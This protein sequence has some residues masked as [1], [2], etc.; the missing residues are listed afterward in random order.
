MADLTWV[1]A[2]S[3]DSANVANWHDLATG[4]PPSA[5]G[6]TDYYYLKED[7][8]GVCSLN[9]QVLGHLIIKQE[10]NRHVEFN[11]ATPTFI[12][13]SFYHGLVMHFK[14]AG[15][16]FTSIGTQPTGTPFYNQPLIVGGSLTYAEG[17]GNHGKETTSWEMVNGQSTAAYLPDGDLGNMTLTSGKWSTNVNPNAANIDSALTHVAA[18]SFGRLQVGI[19]VVADPT[20]VNTQ[21]SLGTAQKH[22]HI[23]G[24]GLSSGLALRCTI[25]ILDFSNC[26]LTLDAKNSAPIPCTNDITNF[27]ANTQF[28]A[29]LEDVVIGNGNGNGNIIT[30][31]AGLT[32]QCSS[33]EIQSG[34][35]LLGSSE[36]ETAISA[37]I[38]CIEKPIIRGTWN[39]EEIS[40]G[41][42][43]TIKGASSISTYQSISNEAHIR[44]A[45][46]MT[47]TTISSA[48][49]NQLWVNSADSNK[50]YFGTSEV[51]GAGG[52]GDITG[53]TIQTDSGAGS[54]ADRYKRLGRLYF[55][56]SNRRRNN[57]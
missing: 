15:T 31:P 6:A 49:A 18:A 50:L 30:I 33:L 54:K 9:H 8:V 24:L 47:A 52:G 38:E 48:A 43:R 26:K 2:A 44:K 45:I 13:I 4:S 19:F 28:I 21:V 12:A 42:Y 53:V 46:T 7:A 11:H 27:G 56:R 37:K 20:W 32:L 17:G 5:L 57:K 39:F 55:G 3:T 16:T 34:S 41:V 10:Y 22:I 1:G 25:D 29:K 36:E 40:D 23:T 51:G 14:Q 35:M